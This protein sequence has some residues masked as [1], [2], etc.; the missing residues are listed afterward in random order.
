[1]PTFWTNR[2]PTL[3][4]RSV[5]GIMSGMLKASYSVDRVTKSYSPFHKNTVFIVDNDIGTS[6]TNDAENVVIDVLAKYPDHQIIYRDTM[7]QWD[8]LLH[9]DGK[10]A[11][12]KP[13]F[14]ESL[15]T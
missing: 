14:H 3:D 13:F 6:I 11:G 12:F 15:D 8:E 10:F 2:R 7:G 5:N 9:L 1:M 4:K